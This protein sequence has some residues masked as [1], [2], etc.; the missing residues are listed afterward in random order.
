MTE[1]TTLIT[2]S[3]TALSL[4]DLVLS[5][6]LADA[7]GFGIVRYFP[8]GRQSRVLYAPDSADVHGSEAVAWSLQ[9]AMLGFDWMPVG[10]AS[11][12]AVQTARNAMEA[13]IS[14][15]SFQVTTQVSGAPAEAWKA[16]PG[17]MTLGGSDGR[18]YVDMKYRVPVYAVT[19][20]VYPIPE[21]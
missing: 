3:R 1:P 18:T 15:F 20:P 9:Q 8:P 17:S 13:A 6:T 16:D 21:V 2:I 4:S 5:G 19:I 11:E 14:Q 7:N 10:A 12:T